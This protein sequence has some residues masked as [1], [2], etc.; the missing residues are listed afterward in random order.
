MQTDKRYPIKLNLTVEPAS[1]K[2]I[3]EQGR[4]MEFADAVSTLAAAHIKDQIVQKV[5]TAQSAGLVVAVG[6]D[7]DDRYG[8]PPKPWPWPGGIW[9]NAL[10]EVATRD[11]VQRFRA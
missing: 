3:V 7:D 8:T 1:I 10:R 6:F 2:K 9:E 4:L 11:V 5:A